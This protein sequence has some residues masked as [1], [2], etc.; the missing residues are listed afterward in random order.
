MEWRTKDFNDLKME[1]SYNH[2]TFCWGGT[3]AG[4]CVARS[5][6][7]SSFGFSSLARIK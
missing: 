3:K 5:R 1:E 2:L 6:G 7:P 4:N